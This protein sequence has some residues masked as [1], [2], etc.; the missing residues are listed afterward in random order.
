MI[1]LIVYGAFIVLGLF[2]RFSFT[3]VMILVAGGIIS[4]IADFALHDSGLANIISYIVGSIAFY[5]FIMKE[6]S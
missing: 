6:V 4:L 3:G 1:Y 2:L 5:F